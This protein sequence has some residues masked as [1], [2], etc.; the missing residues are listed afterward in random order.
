MESTWSEIHP[1]CFSQNSYNIVTKIHDE[2]IQYSNVTKSP[3][4][5]T[6]G[7]PC[8]FGTIK[9]HPAVSEAVK[10]AIMNPLNS[11]YTH[12]CGLK[13][14]RQFLAKTHSLVD[15]EVPWQNVILN[16][17][18]AIALG[19]V[20]RAICNEGDNVLIPSPGYAYLSNLL[21]G[22]KI[23]SKTYSLLPEK[24]WEVDLED[25]ENKIDEKTKIIYLINPS[26][27]TGSIYSRAH[28]QKILNIAEKYKIPILADEIYEDMVFSDVEFV[29]LA[30]LTKTVP[31]I[32]LGGLSKY[33]MVPGWRL[34]WLVFYD[35]NGYLENIVDGVQILQQILLHAPTFIQAALPDIIE[36]TPRDYM[37][38][39]I[40]PFI[41]KNH[42]YLYKE[43]KKL[44]RFLRPIEAQGTIYMLILLNFDSFNNIKDE[45]DFCKKLQ[46]EENLYFMPGSSFCFKDAI[47]FVTCGSIDL[48]VEAIIRLTEFCYRHEKRGKSI[49]E[50]GE[51]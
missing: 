2:L 43:L 35:R 44:K 28:L 50:N 39:E 22:Y 20:V 23:N 4:K 11:G 7:D 16:H 18:G 1:S 51:Y 8:I 36:K 33:Y 3:I 10:K 5:F 26:N 40:M 32:K 48:Y 49:Q 6:Y 46:L 14:V 13:E 34:G 15:Y 12:T 21:P 41:Q 27:P 30:T 37:R 38:N 9:M 17:G 29:P 25:L 19:F 42:D 31:I 24:N 47:R 45:M